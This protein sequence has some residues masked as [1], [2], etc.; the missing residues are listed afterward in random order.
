MS[1]TSK[2]ECRSTVKALSGTPYRKVPMCVSPVRVQAD[3]VV[4]QRGD[5]AL[6]RSAHDGRFYRH[7]W[8]D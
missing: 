4:I 8:I 7:R 2:K 6:M 3:E 5:V 1:K